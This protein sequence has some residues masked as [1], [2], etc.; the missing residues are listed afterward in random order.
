MSNK[1]ARAALTRADIEDAALALIEEVGLEGF[2]TRKLGA[3]LG[4]E[5]MSIY[6]HFP[7]KAHLLDALVDRLLGALPVPDADMPPR[8]RLKALVAAWR[9]MALAHPNFYLW[10]ALH[11]W[12]SRVGVAFLARILDAFADA[13]LDA[14]RA[15]RGFRALGYFVLGAT[16]DEVRGYANGPSAIEPLTEQALQT[17]FPQVAAAGR[18]FVPTE[19]PATFEL[20]LD[21][22]L[23]GLG[24]K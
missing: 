8:Q 9:Q 16:L 3:R 24:V 21:V 5:A 23:D 4:C 2:S 11:R 20:G 22:L 14:Q 6:H 13:G 7:S 12:N 1:P 10:L 15:A 18:F 19:F 17:D